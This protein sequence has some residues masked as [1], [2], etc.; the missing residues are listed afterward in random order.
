MKT[1]LLS[2]VF[3]GFSCFQVRATGNPV[4][5]GKTRHVC[6]NSAPQNE[7]IRTE[8]I[9]RLAGTASGG[10]INLHD[11]MIQTDKLSAS[12]IEVTSGHFL[13]S[14][15]I[16]HLISIAGTATNKSRFGW[17][18]HLWLLVE[19]DADSGYRVLQ[20]GR[21]DAVGQYNFIDADGDG[22]M[23][24]PMTNRTTS[25][26][27]TDCI[28]YKLYSFQKGGFL[29]QSSC[30]DYNPGLRKQGKNK[31]WKKGSA[32]YSIMQVEYK[33]LDNNGTMEILEHWITYCYNGG[34]RQ[35]EIEQRKT[36]K[37]QTRTLYLT[38]GAFKTI[39]SQ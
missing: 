1:L 27:G 33:D 4:T 8:L 17:E 23:E 29:Y 11:V 14:E 26:S 34:K 28:T 6:S 15:N 19:C 24:V 36:T 16:Q 5:D 10:I 25:D 18:N 39:S 32:M 12:Q 21:G 9:A 30:S 31:K 35:N 37:R 13:A 22:L 20:T 38:D 2:T 7:W 3:L